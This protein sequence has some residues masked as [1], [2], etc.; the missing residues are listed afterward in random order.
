[1][2]RLN[3]LIDESSSTAEQEV[4]MAKA[5]SSYLSQRQKRRY[6]RKLAEDFNVYRTPTNLK[7]NRLNYYWISAIAASILLVAVVGPL[8]FNDAQ[9]PFELAESYVEQDAFAHP[10]VIKGLSIS[11]EGNREMAIRFFENGDFIVSAEKFQAII[12]PS[13]E[14]QFFLAL[15]QLKSGEHSEAIISF[16]QLLDRPSAFNEEIRW[17]LSLAYILSNQ[18]GKAEELLSNIG[19]GDWKYDEAQILLKSF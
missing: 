14:D 6:S 9:S 2:A 7:R 3:N 15:S 13:T 1:M 5:V 8:I 4:V 12:E 18:T 16:E 11:D 17:Y 19:S 10:G